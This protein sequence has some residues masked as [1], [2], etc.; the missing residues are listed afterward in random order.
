[1]T[2]PNAIPRTFHGGR[3]YGIHTAFIGSDGRVRTMQI[4]G[5]HVG[6][7][8]DYMCNV[9]RFVSMLESTPGVPSSRRMAWANYFGFESN[10]YAATTPS[11]IQS[12]PVTAG[13]F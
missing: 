1:M 12:G 10:S 6:L 4:G 11:F 13:E 2:E 3:N 5:I 8:S 7:F 9:S